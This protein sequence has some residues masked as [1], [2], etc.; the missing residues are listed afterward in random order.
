V[1][2]ARQTVRD[3]LSLDADGTLIVEHLITVDPPVSNPN[4]APP[5][6]VRSVYRKGP[7]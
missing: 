2:R 3:V 7:R 5:A 6:P 4:V 1:T